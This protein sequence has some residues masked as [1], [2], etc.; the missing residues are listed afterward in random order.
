MLRAFRRACFSDCWL[1][2]LKLVCHKLS[3]PTILCGKP[4]VLDIVL[5]HCSATHYRFPLVFQSDR[6]SLIS[7]PWSRQAWIL[8]SVAI[9]WIPVSGS[10]EEHTL[11]QA[12]EKCFR[13]FYKCRAYGKS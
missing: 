4:I 2:I 3:M 5:R 13:P 10:K 6:Q 8:D 1:R 7:N 12:Q 11:G 9:R